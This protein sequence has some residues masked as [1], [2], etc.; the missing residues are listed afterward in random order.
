[1]IASSVPVC[2]L[3]NECFVFVLFCIL[4]LEYEGLGEVLIVTHRGK[5][6][7]TC[8][9]TLHTYILR[10]GCVLEVALPRAMQTAPLA[11]LS[12]KSVR[13][14]Y[15]LFFLLAQCCRIKQA[16][17]QRHTR[18]ERHYSGLLLLHVCR[19]DAAQHGSTGYRHHVDSAENWSEL[20]NRVNHSVTP[21]HA[22]PHQ[23]PAPQ[24]G[25]KPPTYFKGPPTA[26]PKI[27]RPEQYSIFIPT[28]P[29]RPPPISR[30]TPSL[31]PARPIPAPRKTGSRCSVLYPPLCII[32]SP[33]AKTNKK[34]ASNGDIDHGF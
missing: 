28:S 12:T 14:A 19:V 13:I 25:S 34:N 24:K 1:M 23:H 4:L 22:V 30:A 10:D 3:R 5:L 32:A 18:L 33:T 7:Q 16:E 11:L 6:P 27:T 9:H 8:N 15:Q 2:F 26:P 20:N 29:P 31:I 17:V 21:T